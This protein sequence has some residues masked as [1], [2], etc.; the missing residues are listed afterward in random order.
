MHL[1]STHSLYHLRRS[2]GTPVFLSPF[3]RPG[4]LITLP[5][6]ATLSG[7]YGKEPR[8]ESIAMLRNDL[9]RFVERDVRDWV[10]ERRFIPRFLLA[11]GTFFLVY[12]GLFVAVPDPLP[13]FDEAIIGVGAAIFVFTVLGRRFEHSKAAGA[14]RIA[15]R[16]KVDGIVFSE[17]PFTRELEDL[18]VSLERDER[19]DASAMVRNYPDATARVIEY[20]RDLLK[21]ND[22]RRYRK[23]L[24][25]GR[26]GR[27]TQ[28]R[29]ELGE[30]IPVLVPL[31][32]LLDAQR[33][34]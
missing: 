4:T 27:A 6:D 32:Q 7:H 17:D 24:R 10:A 15:L 2:N 29:I 16:N 14:R 31:Y 11:A 23:E 3:H 8:V 22:Y 20:L 21:R 28:N 33:Q 5:D 19:V 34:P 30:I 13:F 25:R 9:Y 26:L 12:V 1:S 18:M